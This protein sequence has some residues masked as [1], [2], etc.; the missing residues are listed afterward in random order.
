MRIPPCHQMDSAICGALVLH[1]F[2]FSTLFQQFQ[3]DCGREQYL[4]SIMLFHLFKG[5]K[6]TL[7]QTR[8]MSLFVNPLLVVLGVLNETL[9]EPEVDLTLSRLDRVGTVDHVVTHVA[10]EV[11]ADGAGGRLQGL[12][13]LKPSSSR[14]RPGLQ[15]ALAIRKEP[16]YNATVIE[17]EI[18]R[19][20]CDSLPVV[21]PTSRKA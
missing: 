6:L 16:C 15:N 14:F 11:T 17:S 4:P 20:G 12:G 3:L 9:R 2:N 13:T 18:F 21:Q 8:Q 5:T 1:C 7:K 10:T 19:A